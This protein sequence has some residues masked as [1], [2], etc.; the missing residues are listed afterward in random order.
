MKVKVFHANNPTFGMGD[1]PK[2]P[3]EFTH[4]A[5]VE[6]P[7]ISSL[8]D[9][10][11]LNNAQDVAYRLTNHI[12]TDWRENKEVTGLTENARSTSVGDVIQIGD[13]FFEVGMMGFEKIELPD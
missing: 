2:F 12:D 11:Y 4:V 3:E 13:D 9:I 10:Y 1:A 7:I 8:P 6:L 5:D